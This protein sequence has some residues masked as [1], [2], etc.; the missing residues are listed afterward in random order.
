[1]PL[2]LCLI[3]LIL[4]AAVPLMII[5]DKNLRVRRYI[6]EFYKRYIPFAYFFLVVITIIF[7][8]Y[9]PENSQQEAQTEELQLAQ[10]FVKNKQATYLSAYPEQDTFIGR[11][12]IPDIDFKLDLYWSTAQQFIDQENAGV[13]FSFACVPGDKS[14]GSLIL[15]HNYQE[16]KRLSEIQPG[17]KIYLDLSYGQ[18]IYEVSDTLY[19]GKSGDKI[20]RLPESHIKWEIYKPG[21]KK[22][23][24]DQSVL[25]ELLDNGQYLCETLVTEPGGDLYLQTCYPFDAAVTNQIFLAKCKLVEGTELVGEL[26]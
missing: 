16:G 1:M 14:G 10:E 22:S 9:H 7:E 25:D 15:E 21:L 20:T 12:T 5:F 17:M 26:S 23:P 3:F 8:F 11:I 13:L 18:Y 6:L 4:A 24:V 19:G 2:L